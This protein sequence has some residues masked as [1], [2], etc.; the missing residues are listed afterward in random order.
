M[1]ISKNKR[2]LSSY[3]SV[4]LSIS[5]V[6]FM[7][8]AF[9]I[10]AFNAKKISDDFKEKIPI[11]IY[12]KN[13]AKKIETEQLIKKLNLKD[14]TNSISYISKE[15]GAE[16]LINDIGEDFI[17]FY[18]TNPLLNSIDVFLKS[19]FVTTI[20]FD[21]ITNE[22]NN[23]D[24]I[25]EIM[26]DAPLISL[27]NDN[28]NKI[29]YWILGIALFFLSISI[30]VINSSIRLSIYSNRI[31]IKTMQMVGATKRFI[32]K[33]FVNTHVKLGL[34]GSV[35]AAIMLSL[36]LYY[37]QNNFEY[38]NFESEIPLIITMFGAI[39]VFSVIITYLCTY[40]A[41]QKFLKI[42][43]EQLY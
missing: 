7:M 13:N 41:T 26:F 12:L 40:F 35:L 11:T 4:I 34:I 3:F 8:G 27:I 17:E 30:V 2:L 32:R 6:L 18:G 22:L 10:I 37:I 39:S 23:T 25:D 29:K 14:Y 21:E 20:V 24:F 16:I 31:N 15:K 5:I 28:I 36:S 38:F 33:P 1:A 43:I 42:K 9:F 19:E